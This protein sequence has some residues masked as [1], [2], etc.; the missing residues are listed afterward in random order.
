MKL[1]ESNFLL[2]R[3]PKYTVEVKLNSRLCLKVQV[4][5]LL[6]AKYTT[7]NIITELKNKCT[8]LERNLED[9]TEVRPIARAEDHSS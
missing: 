9:K 8:S 3:C 5:S 2:D 4:R 6:D 7:D 1:T